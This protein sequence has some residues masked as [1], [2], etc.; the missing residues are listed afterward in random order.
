MK[1]ACHCLQVMGGAGVTG[2]TIFE[3]VFLEVCALR[4]Y[5]GPIEVHKS[6]LAKKIKRDFRKGHNA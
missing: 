2:D 5:D 3:Q 4:I 1:I 6:S